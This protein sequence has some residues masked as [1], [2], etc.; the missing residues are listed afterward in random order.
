MSE[1][2]PSLLINKFTL[3]ITSTNA[4]FLR[5]L[6]SILRQEVA[7]V[8]WMVILEESSR[9][10]DNNYNRAN[11]CEV[12]SSGERGNEDGEGGGETYDCHFGFDT[13]LGDVHLQ[14]VNLG[15][16]RVSKVQDLYIPA[17]YSLAS[18]AFI[19]ITGLRAYRPTTHRSIQSCSLPLL[20]RSCQSRI[21]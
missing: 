2:S 19:H 1:N 14:R 21:W 4:S 15:I 10:S 11:K 18:P 12:V 9:Y 7:P 17:K 13:F 20:R 6:T 16:L 3:S 8:A 5:Y